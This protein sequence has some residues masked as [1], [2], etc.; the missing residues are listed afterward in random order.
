MF[1][2]SI[3]LNRTNAPKYKKY[4]T[5]GK[6]R[7]SYIYYNN[8]GFEKSLFNRLRE[9]NKKEPL[10]KYSFMK[11]KEEYVYLYLYENPII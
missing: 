11:L 6:G 10:G 1:K 9:D 2:D 8:G 7:D 4:S 3:Y 5:D